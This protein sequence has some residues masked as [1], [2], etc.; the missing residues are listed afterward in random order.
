MSWTCKGKCH[1][2]LLAKNHWSTANQLIKY[3]IIL[4]FIKSLNWPARNN[5]SF[6][7]Y[8]LRKNF[9]KRRSQKMNLLLRT[10]VIRPSMPSVKH[11]GLS[12]KG[13]D[14]LTDCINERS[15]QCFVTLHM[16]HSLEM[17]FVLAVKFT[18]VILV[19]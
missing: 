8:R 9:L 13:S 1:S 5:V 15:E 4:I 18:A 3:I 14:T 16:P 17:H 11:A 10:W 19:L 6:Q 12:F 7:F 2:C